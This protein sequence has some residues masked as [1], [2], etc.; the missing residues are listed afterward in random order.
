M[1]EFL[2]E[3]EVRP[4]LPSDREFF[5]ALRELAFRPSVEALWGWQEVEQKARSEQVFA[6]LPV[7]IV[8]EGGR[9]VGAIAIVHESDHDELELIG[10]LPEVQ[11]RGVGSALIGSAQEEAAQRGVPLR[12]SVLVTNPAARVLYERLGFH[13]TRLEGPRIFMEW[14]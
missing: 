1:P 2:P 3:L 7:E 12:L 13:V 14:S 10:I 9:P 4:A 5:L 8:E 11:G 6:E